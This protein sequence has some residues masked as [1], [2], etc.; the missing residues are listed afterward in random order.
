MHFFEEVTLLF[1]IH[2]WVFANILFIRDDTALVSVEM[3]QWLLSFHSSPPIRGSITQLGE[4]A[5]LHG[6]G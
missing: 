3:E 4:T 5:G 6:A 2:G 1:G